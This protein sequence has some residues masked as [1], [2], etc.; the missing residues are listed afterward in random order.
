MKGSFICPYCKTENACSCE[1]CK[2]F[3]KEGEYVNTWTEDGES[4]VC[5]KC[6]MTYSPSEALEEEFKQRNSS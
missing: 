3:I 6:G 4:H 2:H 5:G 1:T